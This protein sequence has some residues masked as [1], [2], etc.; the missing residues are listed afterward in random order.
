MQKQ[1][2]DGGV[3]AAIIAL[4]PEAGASVHLTTLACIVVTAIAYRRHWIRKMT[5]TQTIQSVG[6]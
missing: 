6:L 1:H 2:S 5:Q 4:L 3:L